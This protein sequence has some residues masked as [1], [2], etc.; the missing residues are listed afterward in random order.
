EA[1]LRR[2]YAVDVFALGGQGRVAQPGLR[3]FSVMRK[4][5]GDSPLRYVIAQLWFASCAA[6]LVG[7][8]S[9]RRRY[10]LV[11]VHNMPDFLVFSAV[12]AKGTGARVIL[13]VHDTMPEAYATKFD[14]PLRH[15]LI[16]LLR[17]EE[18]LSA[19]FAD[20]VITT[21]DLHKAVLRRH[22]IGAGKV[23]V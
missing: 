20:Q 5:W 9:L 1:L 13:D 17:W 8:H 15:P 22:G 3:V 10:C 7:W 4:Y 23:E 16:A 19:R 2:G 11:H 14:L 12:I 18:R 6:L 21:N